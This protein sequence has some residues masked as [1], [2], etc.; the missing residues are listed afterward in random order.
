M[1]RTNAVTY[2]SSIIS[3]G[4]A[5]NA[6]LGMALAPNGDL[7]VM[8]GNDGNAVEVTPAGSQIDTTTLIKNGSVDLFGVAVASHGGGIEFG[9]DG[10]NVLDLFHA[11]SGATS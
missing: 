5:L 11:A 10:A 3:S 4:G 2:G 7:L 8:N 6:P 1:T 9:N